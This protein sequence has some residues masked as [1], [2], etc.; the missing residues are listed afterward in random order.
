MVEARTLVDGARGPPGR[1][2]ADAVRGSEHGPVGHDAL[3]N[4]VS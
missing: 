2:V 4:E 3:G 1:S